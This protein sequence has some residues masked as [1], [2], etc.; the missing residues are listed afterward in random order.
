MPKTIVADS[1]A[2]VPQNKTQSQ[3]RSIS[4]KTQVNKLSTTIAP[5]EIQKHENH[6][7]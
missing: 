5:H 6:Q 3:N 2:T 7:L 4:S 1:N